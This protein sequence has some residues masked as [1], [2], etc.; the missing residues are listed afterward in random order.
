MLRYDL[1]GTLIQRITVVEGVGGLVAGGDAIWVIKDRTNKLARLEPGA[2]DLTDWASLPSS[3]GSLRYAGGYLWLTLDTEDAVARV[4]AENGNLRTATAGHSPAQTVLAGGH[5]FVS[6]RND[7]TVVVL[8]P[9]TLKAV[10][11]P[12]EVGYNPYALAADERSVWV[13]GLGD[14]TLTRIDYR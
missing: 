8:D 4:A 6:S 9:E 2:T 3:A 11:E 1:K 7:N 5:L 13:T 12:I 14:N 10:G